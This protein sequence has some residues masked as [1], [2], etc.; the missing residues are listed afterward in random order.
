MFLES[1]DRCFEN[2]GGFVAKKPLRVIAVSLAL[3]LTAGAGLTKLSLETD[4]AKLWVP[5]SVSATKRRNLLIENYGSLDVGYV[6]ILLTS[7]D[8][9]SVFREAILLE[10]LEIHQKLTTEVKDKNGHGFQD[11]CNRPTPSTDCFF[12]NILSVFDYDKNVIRAS[13]L[14]GTLISTIESKKPLKIYAFGSEYDNNSSLVRA[15]A[16]SFSYVTGVEYY[17][18]S[19]EFI[20]SVLNDIY[21]EAKKDGTRQTEIF[22]SSSRSLD[23]EVNRLIGNDSFLFAISIIAIILVL[24]GSLFTRS[25]VT[26][27]STLG[28]SAFFII[29]LSVA[30][31]FGLMGWCGIKANSLCF[32][33]PFVV[34]GVSVDDIIIILEFFQREVDKGTPAVERMPIALRQAGSSI[35]LTSISTVVAFASAALVDIPGVKSFGLCAMFSFLWVYVLTCT[36]F[37]AFLALDQRRTNQGRGCLFF[38]KRMEMKF[39]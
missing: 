23:D 11:Y 4:S 6:D 24:A 16:L 33:S 13:A 10:A 37:V 30:F 39:R 19:V 3:S 18:A 38:V 20:G 26:S 17:E 1:V 34:T 35:T 7:K 5:T 2:L 22:I 32:I 12:D 9:G 29:I 28:M 15:G 36:M 31:S 27:R 21:W 8:G 14:N 25:F